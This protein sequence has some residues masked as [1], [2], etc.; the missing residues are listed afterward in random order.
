VADTKN[1]FEQLERDLRES[2]ATRSAPLGFTRRVMARVEAREKSTAARLTLWRRIFAVAVVVATCLALVLGNRY[3]RLRQQQIEGEHARD[4]VILAL[5]I[6]H[7]TLEEVRV[8]VE[9]KGKDT[10]P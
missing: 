6:T 2:L 4:Q 10:Q 7:S 5:R 1:E 9:Q 3:E 8:K